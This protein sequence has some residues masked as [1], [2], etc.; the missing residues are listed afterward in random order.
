[1][2][3]C[4]R[5]R[6]WHFIL[7]VIFSLLGCYGPTPQAHLDERLS[8]SGYIKRSNAEVVIVFVPGLYGDA[9]STWTNDRNQAYWP[10]LISRDTAF[11]NSDV[12]VYAYSSPQKRAIESMV[13]DLNDR[14]SGDE[15]FQTHKRVVF[16]CHSLGGV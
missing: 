4:I 6:R 7:I 13:L 2:W 15:V 5:M 8:A 10:D 16:V 11:R 12:Y 3:G 1:M 9:V 14:L